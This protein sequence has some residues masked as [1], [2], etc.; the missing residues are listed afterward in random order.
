MP[1]S[2]IVY[3]SFGFFHR[4]SIFAD[5]LWRLWIAFLF[6]FDALFF[7]ALD[8]SSLEFLWFISSHSICQSFI[9]D[10]LLFYS[11]LLPFFFSFYLLYSFNLRGCSH[12]TT[13]DFSFWYAWCRMGV[14]DMH[15]WMA[16]ARNMGCRAEGHWYQ[17]CWESSLVGCYRDRWEF[18]THPTYVLSLCRRRIWSPWKNSIASMFSLPA[19][20]LFLSFFLFFFLFSL[21]F[22]GLFSDWSFHD[23]YIVWPHAFYLYLIV[24]Q[25][26][27][28]FLFF[29]CISVGMVAGSQGISWTFF[30]CDQSMLVSGWFSCF[31]YWRSR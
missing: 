13:A 25:F 1:W 7:P 21:Y 6:V 15:P 11:L 17:C 10:K 8:G 22:F 5:E 2:Y 12:R 28:F 27:S 20:P 29:F 23:I 14:L 4:W 30:V 18:W 26:F 31:F 3:Y 24:T 19:L 9:F 16:C